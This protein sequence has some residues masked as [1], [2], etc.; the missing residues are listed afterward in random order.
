MI[1]TTTISLISSNLQ[2]EIRLTALEIVYSGN[3][4]SKMVD[5]ANLNL[6]GHKHIYSTDI[7][8]SLV[9][10][11]NV[12]NDACILRVEYQI[13]FHRVN[14]TIM[15][16]LSNSVS[17]A[18]TLT[19]TNGDFQKYLISEA[20][21]INCSVLYRAVVVPRISI[22]ESYSIVSSL[23]MSTPTMQP[24]MNLPITSVS[25][26][27]TILPSAN[28]V[29]SNSINGEQDVNKS[30]LI[31]VGTAVGGALL[32]ICLFISIYY[33]KLIFTMINTRVKSTP[34]TST[35]DSSFIKEFHKTDFN[36]KDDLKSKEF[37]IQYSRYGA[38]TR[39]STEKMIALVIDNS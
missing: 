20:H 22:N 28:N 36:V 17:Q 6:R 23:L 30:N 2:F 18:L 21:R 11:A 39:M 14:Q 9:R 12:D 3:I 7:I 4:S 16:A 19:T 27:P 38:S 25:N 37:G 8:S 33:R 35:L 31:T 15:N 1:L 32:F 26:F 34:S 5:T 29:G 24:V 13:I 10:F